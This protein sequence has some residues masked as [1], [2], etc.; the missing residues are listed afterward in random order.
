M[1]EYSGIL[2]HM[3]WLGQKVIRPYTRQDGELPA[4]SEIFFLSLDSLLF[5]KL[6]FRELAKQKSNKANSSNSYPRQRAILDKLI[7]HKT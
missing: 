2:H 6:E 7:N 1:L 3:R 5:E 4:C